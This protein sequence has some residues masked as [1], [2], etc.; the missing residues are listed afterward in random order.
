MSIPLSVPDRVALTAGTGQAD[1]ELTAFD[2]ALHDA[3]AHDANVVRV[4]SIIPPD[5]ELDVEPPR[6][7]LAAEIEVGGLYP[8]V[9]AKASAEAGEADPGERLVAA[10]GAGWLD[11]GYGVNVEAQGVGTTAEAV[12][13]E[14]RVM[15]SE[16]A[17]TRDASLESSTVTVASE[18]VP[19]SGAAAAVAAAVYL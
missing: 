11:E 7:D 4:T 9:L 14:C 5:A 17:E 3:G 12:E 8:A 2:R 10:I 15:L 19:V 1:T 6:A 16:M 18:P 13:E